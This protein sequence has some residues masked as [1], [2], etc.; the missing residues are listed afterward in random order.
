M[1]M[2]S[3]DPWEIIRDSFKELKEEI[4]EFGNKYNASI[5]DIMVNLTK[6]EARIKNLEDRREEL[7]QDL[8][9]IIPSIISLLSFA[10]WI[11]SYI[12]KFK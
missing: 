10:M 8:K 5:I 3:L 4:K 12:I 1:D 7:R 11:Y 6:L 9:W 2:Q